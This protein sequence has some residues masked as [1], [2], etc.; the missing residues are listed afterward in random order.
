MAYL[1]HKIERE[2]SRV[3]E[4][5]RLIAALSPKDILRRGYAIVYANGKASDGTSLKAGSIVS[6]ELARATFSAKLLKKLK[7]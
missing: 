6:I 1:E 2:Q 7:G 3:N 4:L 5:S